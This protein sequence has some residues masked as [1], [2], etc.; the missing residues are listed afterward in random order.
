MKKLLSFIFAE[1]FPT[2][3]TP[4]GHHLFYI[5]NENDYV[6]R[7]TRIGRMPKFH[8]VNK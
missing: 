7:K 5:T 6:A 2:K 3:V 8:T 1:I 4:F